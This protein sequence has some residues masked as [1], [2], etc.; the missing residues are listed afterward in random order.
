MFTSPFGSFLYDFS[1][2]EYVFNSD[3]SLLATVGGSNALADN[4]PVF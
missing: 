2:D 1:R 3:I 4:F